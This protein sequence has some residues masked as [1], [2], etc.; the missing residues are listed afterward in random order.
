MQLTNA[1]QKL[2]NDIYDGCV[3]NPHHRTVRSLV[4]KG[5]ITKYGDR[6]ELTPKAIA[7]LNS[8]DYYEMENTE[9][10]VEASRHLGEQAVRNP[11]VIGVAILGM[12][13]GALIKRNK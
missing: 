8:E 9:A 7:Y 11:A 1:Q 6:L 13:L 10:I 12:A 3:K 4:N 5:A 2:I